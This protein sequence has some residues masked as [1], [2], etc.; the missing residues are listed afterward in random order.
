MLPEKSKAATRCYVHEKADETVKEQ[1][2]RSV[3]RDL[4][5]E[6][7][8]QENRYCL[9]HLPEDKKVGFEAVVSERLEIQENDFAW[10]H[11]PVA[12]NFKNLRFTAAA[13]FRRA[14]FA[15]GA[16]F[17]SAIFEQEA[18]FDN[19]RFERVSD[20]TSSIFERKVS[21]KNAVFAEDTTFYS[22]E[23]M[24]GG[25]FIEAVFTEDANFSRANFKNGIAGFYNANFSRF[26]SFNGATFEKLAAFGAATF[27]NDV[28]FSG[29]VCHLSASFENARFER[30]VDFR[31]RVFAGEAVFTDTAFARN[32][33]FR[34]TT[35]CGMVSFK[36]AK[37]EETA[38]VSF[39]ETDFQNSAYFTYAIFKGY[40]SFA[41]TD[42]NKSFVGEK[43]WLDL[44]N[45]RLEKPEGISFHTVRLH[46]N[47]FVNSDLRKFVFTCVKW[48]NSD[49]SLRSVQKELVK[50]RYR[51]IGDAG[52]LLTITLRQLAFNAEENNRYE[53]ASDLRR[54]SFEGEWLEKNAP[55]DSWFD[56]ILGAI[57]RLKSNFGKTPGNADLLSPLRFT[58]R[59]IYQLIF[60]FDFI[61][62]LYRL[63][64][65]YGESWRRAAL[66]LVIVVD[67]AAGLFATPLCQFA[68]ERK[69]LGFGEAIFYSLRV[70]AL[71]RPDPQPANDFAKGTVTIETIFAPLQAAMLALAIWRKFM[72]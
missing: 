13:S 71:Q 5:A 3:C 22:A 26:S 29:S 59:L 58:L 20:F 51:S 12:A 40:V 18:I 72:R 45:A 34:K 28:D 11:F 37:F 44:Q 27:S 32:A 35:F 49:G 62:S 46:P 16:N 50:L 60:R 25:D 14:V 43:F 23:F 61:H 31:D 33:D 6:H 63:L 2:N 56:D 17:E 54:M 10:V 67:V 19:A 65:F 15:A 39:G 52:G 69:G 30:D 1:V 47:W 21:F 57:N 24:A 53:E 66:I 38:E 64:S 9:L 68:G 70:V 36:R 41:G 48:E 55:V 4:A 42:P 8:Y 7:I